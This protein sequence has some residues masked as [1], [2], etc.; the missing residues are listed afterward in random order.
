MDGFTAEDPDVLIARVQDQVAA[1]QQRAQAAQ[2]MRA[3]VEA[4]RG[5]AYSQRRELSVTVDA[6]GRL[7]DVE[8]SDAALDLRARD[9]SRLIVT[10]A[11]AASRDAG[12]QAMDLAVT[13]FG[14]DSPV[15]ARLRDEVQARTG[16]DEEQ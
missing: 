4:V 16:Q 11:Q 5:T 15:V 8:L 6:S 1:A 10:T 9:L 2:Q 12:Q 7:V 13:A 3:Q 14:E